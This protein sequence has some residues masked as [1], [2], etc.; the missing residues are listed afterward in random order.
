MSTPRQRATSTTVDDLTGNEEGRYAY[1]VRWV[2]YGTP[3]TCGTGH[4][5]DTDDDP[6]APT[7]RVTFLDEYVPA[8]DHWLNTQRR[9]LLVHPDRLDTVRAAIN[10]LPGGVAL[11]D[12]RADPACPLDTVYSVMADHLTGYRYTA[13][14]Q[15]RTP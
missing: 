3:I 14:R 2:M 13:D 1:W 11:Y 12:V 9:Y 7:G 6:P 4:P 8:L 10:D 15:D 5:H